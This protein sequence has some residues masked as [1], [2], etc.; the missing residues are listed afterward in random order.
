MM[1]RLLALLV[2]APAL[3]AAEP[4]E[5][6]LNLV[7]PESSVCFV[8]QNLREQAATV[9]KSPF[10][11]WAAD[12]LAPVLSDNEDAR[13]L[14]FFEELITKVIGVSLLDLRDDIFGDCIAFAYQPG[15][16]GQP[17]AERGVVLLHA[18][19]AAKLRTLIESLNDFQKQAG[20]LKALNECKY[21]ERTYWQRD[22]GQG[23]T[24]Y[25]LLD[26]RLFAFAVKE[27]ALKAIIDR[28]IEPRT[29]IVLK[30][31]NDLKLQDAFLTCWLSPRKLDA[32][33]AAP[34]QA[35]AT[36][37]AGL[38]QIAR[39]WGAVDQCALYLKAASDLELGAAVT[40]RA[41]AMPA[42]VR[43]LFASSPSRSPFWDKAFPDDAIL[44]LAGTIDADTL[45]A[46]VASFL[47]PEQRP[48]LRKQIEQEVGAVVGKEKVSAVM[49]ALG[50]QGGLCLLKSGSTGG[51]LP[52]LIAAIGVKESDP[53]VAR[54]VFDA[55]HFYA[56]ALAV[57]YNRIH[58]DQITLE[59][60]TLE[61]GSAAMTI[62]TASDPKLFPQGVEPAFGHRD[63]YFLATS[64]KAAL[65]DVRLPPNVIPDPAPGRDVPVLR[66]SGVAC[67]EQIM[68]HRSTLAE[69]LTQHQDREA[70]Q[71]MEDLDSLARYL[72]AVDVAQL[73]I[74]GDGRS[75]TMAL[76]VKLIKPLK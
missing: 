10:A 14:K 33:L 15:P 43:T 58:D 4:R 12:K 47:P 38:A 34:S 26:G 31:L 1:H 2:F 50:P 6:V 73:V 67:R 66:I 3:S 68:T 11:K 70:K 65:R 37:R 21:R 19:D 46:L 7:P 20:E 13:K 9:A 30:D 25:Y 28:Q 63:G 40:Y 62:V 59:T 64:H 5:I 51:P 57:D 24:E 17:D 76:R 41:D 18:R 52:T 49:A 29:S 75:R 39:V 27:E 69:F 56:K 48:M 23:A 55:V 35:S 60:G 45:I 42:E 32:D 71:I 44:A 74:A 54:T 72:E 36:E 22:R 16:A 53:I 8:V 61:L